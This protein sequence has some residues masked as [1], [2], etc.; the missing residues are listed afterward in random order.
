MIIKN[1]INIIY[2]S[3]YVFDEFTYK[4]GIMAFNICD[5]KNGKTI[6]LVEDLIDCF[7]VNI[8]FII[9]F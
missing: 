5:A 8:F 1:Y 7:F 4:K 3:V 2:Q 9:L 6:D